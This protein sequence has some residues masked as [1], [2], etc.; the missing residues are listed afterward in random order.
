MSVIIE[1][2]SDVVCPWCWLGLR[3]LGEAVEQVKEDIDVDVFYRPYQLDPTVP[4]GGIPY[5]EYMQRKF[6]TG[7]DEVVESNKNRW[8]QMRFAL[9]QTGNNEGI[10]FEFDYIQVRPNTLD[11]HRVIRWAQGQ[12][13]AWA[14][15]ELMFNAVFHE[16]LDLGDTAVLADIAAKA[17]LDRALIADLLDGDADKASTLQEEV[18]YRQQGITGV[19]TFI[20]NRKVAV[21]GAQEVSVLTQFIRD[22]EAKHPME[23]VDS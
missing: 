20:A 9:E 22:A 13:Q 15:K 4:E 7:S 17:G 3:R 21:Q 10:P 12:G 6:G 14:V 5:K 18:F 2:V 11:A 8:I 23:R 16:H 1:M 19:P